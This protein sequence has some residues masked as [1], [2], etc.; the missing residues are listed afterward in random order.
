MFMFKK[1]G[2]E[3]IKKDKIDGIDGIKFKSYQEDD[4]KKRSWNN[5]FRG[6]LHKN[7]AYDTI[8]SKKRLQS[9]FTYRQDNK[10]K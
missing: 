9:Y 10:N 6:F 4:K 8:Y 2:Y 1:Y 7:G 5:I 3:Q